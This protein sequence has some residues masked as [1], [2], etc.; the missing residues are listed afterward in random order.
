[1]AAYHDRADA[2]IRHCPGCDRLVYGGDGLCPDCAREEAG[3]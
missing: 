1:M 3:L 2:K